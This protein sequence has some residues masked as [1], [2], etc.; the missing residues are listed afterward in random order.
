MGGGDPLHDEMGKVEIIGSIA[1]IFVAITG[2]SK[3][4]IA[5]VVGGEGVPDRVEFPDVTWTAVI[6]VGNLRLLLE[7]DVVIARIDSSL[8]ASTSDGEGLVDCQ[9]LV[10]KGIEV[11]PHERSSRMATEISKHKLA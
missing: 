1:G 10:S 5:A 8:I 11:C 6:D 2:G 3:A 9:S 7:G 4:D